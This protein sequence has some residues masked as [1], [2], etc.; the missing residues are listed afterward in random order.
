MHFCLAA[1]TKTPPLPVPLS[2]V[3]KPIDPHGSWLMAHSWFL[4]LIRPNQNHMDKLE[5]VGK[6]REWGK[7]REERKTKKREG[8]KKKTQTK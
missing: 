1:L 7:G 4:Y 2:L 3:L 8:K 6:T 5:R